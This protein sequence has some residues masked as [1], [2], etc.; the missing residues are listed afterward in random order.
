MAAG[1]VH[2]PWYATVFRG[3]KLEAALLEIAPH[4]VRYGATEWEIY[5]SKD[6]KYKLLQMATFENKADFEA[7]WYSTDFNHWRARY[8][9]YYQVPVLYVWHDLVARGGLAAPHEVGA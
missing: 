3:D 2:I 8:S 6:D 1:V 5:R 4:A 9:S 7:Y